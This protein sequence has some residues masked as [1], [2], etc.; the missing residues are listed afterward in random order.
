MK[1]KKGIPL[2]SELG[3][4]RL[5]SDFYY[6]LP[7]DFDYAG[8][9]HPG[10]EFVYVDKGKVSVSADNATYILKKGEMVC[11]KPYEFHKVKAYEGKAA[12]IIICFESSDE[13]MA[14]FNNKIL[15][16][17][18]RQK[19]YLNDIAD[20]GKTIFKPKPP[21]EISAD[22]QMD[23]SPEATPLKLQ[24]VKNAIQVLLLSLVNSDTTEKQNRITL[25]EHI[26]QRKTL[27]KN[28]INYLNQNLDKQLTL[29]DISGRFSYSLSSVKRIFKEE[30]G[31]S[32]ISYLNSLRM[33]KAKE[34]LWGTDHAIGQIAFALGFSNVYYF[35]AAFKKK[36]GVSPSK[37]RTAYTDKELDME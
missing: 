16:V 27:T 33:H 32:I 20:M 21:L 3:V 19:Q 36:W 4:T 35:S 8:E 28:I 22:G 37:F 34:L 29:E 11:H 30:T 1:D 25:Y 14:Y 6:E 7:E 13:Y 9:R 24:F 10:W 31:C 26:S 17:N 2:K 5:I 18:Q 23:P 12:I 15:S